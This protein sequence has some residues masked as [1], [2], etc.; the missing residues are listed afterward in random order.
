MQR[1]EENKLLDSDHSRYRSGIG[2]LLYLAKHTRPD[3][4]KAVRELS[5]VLSGPGETAW[6]EM[7]RIMQHEEP[8]F[9]DHP[10]EH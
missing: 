1:T 8:C 9:E 5:K 7:K 6:K 4:L 2:M 10:K 3:I